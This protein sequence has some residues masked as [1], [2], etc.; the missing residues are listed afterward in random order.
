MVGA[1]AAADDRRMKVLSGIDG[2]F[3]HLE[4]AHAPMHVGSLNL[5]DPGRGSAS[6]LAAA[7]TRQAE[8]RLHLA[9]IFRRRLA[10]MP[11]DLANPAWVHD[12]AIDLHYH[13]QRLTL[14]HPGT[15]AQLE[16]C[17][18]RLHAQPLDRERPL[19]RMVVI[20]GLESGQVGLYFQ[21]H[22]AVLDGQAGIL[23]AH[24]L[25]DPTPKRR[26]IARPV[27]A[28]PAEHPGAGALAAAA[29]RHD[30]A[31]LLQWVR[32]LPDTVRALAGVAAA[33]AGPAR[34]G[35][36]GNFA[37]GPK[38]PLNVPITAERSYAV[39]SL[40][41][42]ALKQIAKAHD[43]KLN[44]VVL[45]LC[46]GTLRRWLDRHG[47]VPDKPLIAA[48]PIS[49]RAP[50][51]G[52]YTTQAT[53]TLVSLE[54]QIDDALQRL[55][56][57]RDAS[58]AAK[59]LAQRARGIMPTDFPT[60]GIAPVMHAVAS[61]YEWSHLA[62]ATDP[63]ANVVVSNVAGPPTPLYAAGARMSAYWPLSIVE[64]GLALN[65]T[66]VSYAGSMGFGFTCARN[67]VPDAREL[68]QALAASFDELVH[69]THSRP[70][71]AKP[72][73]PA[74]ARRTTRTTHRAST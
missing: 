35:L 57:I 19:W 48:M 38:T 27:A 11:L 53:M 60:I 42:E 56:A 45:A 9:P 28:E 66:V 69:D 44:D 14:P 22:H 7:L 18:A 6:H 50:G 24:A 72:P 49:L 68:A 59:A 33:A 20:D 23:L 64:H 51:D 39:S 67:A 16:D 43:A 52:E 37:F 2:S 21:V 54:T 58:A 34:A 3:L 55:R 31:Q 10:R 47:G 13:V 61:L 30:G 40:P 8:G 41:L 1:C 4:T 29:L 12:D 36:G 62:G 15:L 32:H 70:P 71:A 26:A 74:S 65:L 46:S 17:V 63:I 5:F 73:K 25:W